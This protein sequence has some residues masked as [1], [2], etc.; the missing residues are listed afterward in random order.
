MRLEKEKPVLEAFWAW[1][2]SQHPT[3]NTRLDKALTYV[4]E[5]PPGDVHDLSG[6]RTLQLHQ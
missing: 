6:R 2:D 1:V 3:R 5:E 4:C